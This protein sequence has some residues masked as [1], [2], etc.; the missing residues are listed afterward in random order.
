MKEISREERSDATLRI[1]SSWGAIAG[2]AVLGVYFIGFMIYHSLVPTAVSGWLLTQ[3]SNHFAATIGVP[4]S[5]ISAACV[6]LVLKTTAGPIEF[7]VFGLKFKGAAGPVVL[8]VFCFLS[9]VL[10]L[11]LLWDM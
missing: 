9:M 3:I 8:W 11:Y 7:E 2:V 6:V 4:L 5:G 10:A 1:L